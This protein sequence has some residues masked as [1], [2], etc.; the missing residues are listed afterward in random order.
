MTN[1]L[2]LAKLDEDTKLQLA[3]TDISSLIQA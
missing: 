1:L 3:E 2:P